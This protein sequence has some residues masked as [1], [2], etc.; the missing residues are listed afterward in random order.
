MTGGE[1]ME[2]GKEWEGREKSSTRAT[3]KGRGWEGERKGE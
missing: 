1:G 3:S 2:G